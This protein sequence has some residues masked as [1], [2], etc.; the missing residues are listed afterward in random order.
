MCIPTRLLA[1][2]LKITILFL[3]RSAIGCCSPSNRKRPL[4]KFLNDRE[5]CQEKVGS[6]SWSTFFFK[7]YC[8]RI[9][10][11]VDG[12]LNIGIFASRRVVES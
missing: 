11:R 8:F 9:S 7:E 12:I 10:V 5:A 2:T 6:G 4:L 1:T 3:T